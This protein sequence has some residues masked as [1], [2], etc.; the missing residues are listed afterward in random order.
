MRRFVEETGDV[1]RAAAVD[2][3]GWAMAGALSV[4][5]C[6]ISR[7][8]ALRPALKPRILVVT[9]HGDGG[10]TYVSVM[11]AL[12]SAQKLQVA[13]DACVLAPDH[14]LFLQQATHLTGGAYVKPSLD[15][16]NSLAQFLLT[17]FLADAMTRRPISVPTLTAIDY[18][19]TCFCH[20]KTISIGYVCSSCLSVFCSF[21]LT[22]STCGTK[23]DLPRNDGSR[24]RRKRR[25]ATS[26][27]R[28]KPA[29][30]SA[31]VPAPAPPE[32]APAMPA[33]PAPMVIE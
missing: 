5:L 28:A 1:G 22:C 14:S 7:A 19:A 17:A 20:R 12:F 27:K 6:R 29:P 30:A 4:A 18:R 23:F 21:A 33:D 16:Q 26:S 32:P 11:N 24:K 13:I 25:K 31:P 15:A 3:G 9:S 2:G 8:V 10:S